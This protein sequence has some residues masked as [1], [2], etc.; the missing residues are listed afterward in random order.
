MLTKHFIEANRH[1]SC[2]YERFFEIH[3]HKLHVMLVILLSRVR[4]GVQSLEICKPFSPSR[5]GDRFPLLVG[6]RRRLW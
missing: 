1:L 3:I 2:E 6:L 4:R 5:L